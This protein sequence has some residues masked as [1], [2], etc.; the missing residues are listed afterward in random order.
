MTL[1]DPIDTGGDNGAAVI[2]AARAGAATLL[3]LPALLGGY[4]AGGALHDPDTCWLL[5]LGSWILEHGRLPQ[6]DPFSFTYALVWNGQP[7]VLYQWLSEL[8]FSLAYKA[9]ALPGLLALCAI[10]LVLAFYAMPLRILCREGVGVASA[11]GLT[12][13]MVLAASFHFLARPE[14]FSYLLTA[15]WIDRLAAL[16]HLPGRAR[17][18]WPAVVTFFFL[19]VIWC[20]LHTGFV[21]GLVLLVIYALSSVV[22]FAAAPAGTAKVNATA[23]TALGASLAATL[24]NPWGIGLWTY[25][26]RLFFPAFNQHVVELKPVTISDLGDPIF[27]PYLVLLCVAAIVAAPIIGVSSRRDAQIFGIAALLIAVSGLG[28]RRLVP[29]AA[30]YVLAGLASIYRSKINTDDVIP[31]G[32]V[33]GQQGLYSFVGNCQREVERIVAPGTARWTVG[34]GVMAVL[35]SVLMSLLIIPPQ[36]PQGSNVF[37]PP[38]GAIEYLAKGPPPGRVLNDAQFGDVMIWHLTPCPP[39]FMDTR[40]DMYGDRLVEDYRSMTNCADNWQQL[41]DSYQISWVFL[42]P[43]SRLAKTLKSEPRWSVV[44]EDEHSIIMS[45]AREQ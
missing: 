44:H 3:I 21:A 45:R 28:C 20:N 7:V 42:K 41:L 23:L 14:I 25:L 43:D 39:V 8:I 36:L 15:I 11:A 32:R 38:L 10:M 18:N 12:L 9:L 26:P 35:G 40:F 33:P 1:A 4:V 5:K 22:A 34:A 27:W 6:T 17:I 16:D 31:S 24:I 29:F 37:R 2:T 19:M 30:L 13:L